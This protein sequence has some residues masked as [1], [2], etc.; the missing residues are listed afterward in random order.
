MGNAFDSFKEFTKFG[1]FRLKKRANAI[2]KSKRVVAGLAVGV[3]AVAKKK[4]NRTAR[5]FVSSASHDQLYCQLI[6]PF[7]FYLYLI[8]GSV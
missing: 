8:S 3:G 1:S 5:I 2:K 4:R 6:F 7:R